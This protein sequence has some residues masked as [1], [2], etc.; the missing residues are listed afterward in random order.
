MVLIRENHGKAAMY[1]KC[2]ILICLV[3]VCA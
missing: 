3:T 1:E 2:L